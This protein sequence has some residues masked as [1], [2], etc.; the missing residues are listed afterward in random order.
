MV[1][2]LEFMDGRGNI[3]KGIIIVGFD[4]VEKVF[5]NYKLIYIFVFYYIGCKV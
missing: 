3:M 5:V 2:Y 1:V 4:D